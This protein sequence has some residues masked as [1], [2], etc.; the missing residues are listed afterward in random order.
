MAIS[1]AFI[2]TSVGNIQTLHGRFG[3]ELCNMLKRHTGNSSVYPELI[4]INNVIGKIK[5]ILYAYVPVGNTVTNDAVNDLSETEM[6]SLINYAYKVLNKY[7]S[8]IF[9]PDNPN[10]YL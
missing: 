9:L 1:Q 4:S 6:M 8:N 3:N 2:N 7:N 5:D 10:V